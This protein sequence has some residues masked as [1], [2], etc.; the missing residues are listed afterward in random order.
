MINKEYLDEIK[1]RVSKTTVAPWIASIEGGDHESCIHFIMAGIPVGENIW[2]EKRGEDLEIIG[3][4]I[5][6]L[7]FIA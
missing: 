3:A 2:Q 1:A 7:D 4:T 5:D 6:D